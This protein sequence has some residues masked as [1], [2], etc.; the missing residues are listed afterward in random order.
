MKNKI[1]SKIMS[2][3]LTC[4][5]VVSSLSGI[6]SADELFTVNG[7]TAGTV[8]DILDRTDHESEGCRG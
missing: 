6:V 2:V 4:F 7:D 3:S 8:Q 1:F 5:I